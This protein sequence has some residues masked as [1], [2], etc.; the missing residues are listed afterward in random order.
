MKGSEKNFHHFIKQLTSAGGIK[1]VSSFAI[2]SGLSRRMIYYYL[3]ELNYYLKSNNSKAYIQGQKLTAKQLQLCNQLLKIAE[4]KEKGKVFSTDEREIIMIYYLLF[5]TQKLTIR[6]FEE[7][8]LIS[9]NT[10]IKDISNLRTRLKRFDVEL[11]VNKIKG[12]YL[13]IDEFRQRQFTYIFFHLLSTPKLSECTPF[14]TNMI[15]EKNKEWTNKKIDALITMIHDTSSI[16]LKKIAEDDAL[17]I[18]QT[19]LAMEERKNFISEI[20]I[21]ETFDEIITNRIEYEA[22][23]KMTRQY[24]HLIGREIQEVENKILGIYLLCVEKDIDEH[25]LAPHFQHLYTISEQIIAHFQSKYGITFENLEDTIKNVQ[26]Y[27]KVAFYRNIFHMNIPN[28]SYRIVLERYPKVFQIVKRTIAELFECLPVFQLCFPTSFSDDMLSDLTVVFEDAILREQTRSYTLRALIVSDSSKV[29][30]SLIQSHITQH[31]QTIQVVGALSPKKVTP[32]KQGVELCITTLNNYIHHEGK[33]VY[34]HSIP[35]E[36]DI[37]KIQQLQYEFFH[38]RK[39]RLK[40]KYLLEEFNK[41]NNIDK[42]LNEIE[43][44]YLGLNKTRANRKT[45]ALQDYIHKKS[46][47]SN[48]EIPV[49][50]EKIIEKSCQQFIRRNTISPQYSETLMALVNDTS[51]YQN[52]DTLIICGDYR[53]GAL[54]VDIQ[55]NHLSESICINGCEVRTIYVLVATENMLQVPLIFEIEDTIQ[56]EKRTNN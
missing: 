2:V 24:A 17:I 16:L 18:A 31:L 28:K 10:V 53:K 9:K 25:Y 52:H 44:V 49:T 33:T 41:T 43:H 3:D 5:E 20:H 1:R 50:L 54:H 47:I 48:W 11:N 13:E 32:I 42:T 39:R 14:I 34:I 26:T 27:M 22:A 46:H 56:K 4:E 6:F 12:Y 35:T 15:Q 55:I 8:F 36:E 7:L 23:K 30:C 40:I 51:F 45:Y 19:L 38:S 29:E 37:E 21:P